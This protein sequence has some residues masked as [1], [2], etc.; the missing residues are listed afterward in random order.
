MPQPPRYPMALDR[1]PHRLRDDESDLWDGGGRWSRLPT[2]MHDEIRL[3]C[4][5]T[6]LN[7]MTEFRRPCHPV[8]GR[9]HSE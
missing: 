8:L 9:E 4:P 2:C 7:G 3:R 5:H 6:A 1:T